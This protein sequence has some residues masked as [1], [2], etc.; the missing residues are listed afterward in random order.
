MAPAFHYKV[1]P[2]TGTYHRVEHLT[3]L[4]GKPKTRLERSKHSSMLGQFVSFEY[5]PC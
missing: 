5:D 2:N 1:P 3:G 4:I